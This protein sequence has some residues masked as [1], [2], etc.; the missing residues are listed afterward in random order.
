MNKLEAMDWIKTDFLPVELITN[1]ETILQQ[2]D[3]AIRYWNVY[4]AFKYVKMYDGSAP[5]IQLDVDFKNVV[6]VLPATTPD[7]ILQNY[8]LW[9][10][11]GIM[12]I[13]NLSSDLVT[14]SE[15]YKNYRYYIGSDFHWQF[16][17]SDDPAIGPYLYIQNAPSNVTRFCVV[18]TKRILPNEDIKSEFVLNFILNYSKALVKAIEGNTLR[19]SDAIGVKNDGQQLIS[20]AKEELASLKEE[21]N[22]S[23][24]WFSFV[25]RF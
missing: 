3:N 5:R 14:L 12:V 8:P 15:A 11:T 17:K 24:R 1:D 19:K 16:E 10:L 4:S 23:G 18:G 25:K 7:A 22:K 21:I 20:E 2:I 9:T 13:D 6:Q